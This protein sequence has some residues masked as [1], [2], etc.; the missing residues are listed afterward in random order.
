MSSQ[1]IRNCI[2]GIEKNKI[3]VGRIIDIGYTADGDGDGIIY[4]TISLKKYYLQV[5]KNELRK[6][7]N[8]EG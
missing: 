8:M 5:F 1:H 6:R 3:Q 4:D 7:Q 2:K